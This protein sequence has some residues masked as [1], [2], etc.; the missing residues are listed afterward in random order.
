ML[1]NVKIL[2]VEDEKEIRELF[3]EALAKEGFETVLAKDG[4]EGLKKLEEHSFDLIIADI[5]MPRMDGMEMLLKARRID[6]DCFFIIVTGYAS[7]ES[8][9]Q[10]LQLGAYDYLQKPVDLREALTKFNHA[11]A[12][13]ILQKKISLIQEAS[14]RLIKV[15]D[16]EKGVK[17]TLQIILEM[18]SY[19]AATVLIHESDRSPLQFVLFHPDHQSHVQKL[20]EQSLQS[21][22]R[23]SN[24][25]VSKNNIPRIEIAEPNCTRSLSNHPLTF[26]LKIQNKTIGIVN[27]YD[28]DLDPQKKRTRDD[29]TIGM[30]QVL[31]NQFGLMVQTIQSLL[32]VQ[33]QHMQSIL[34]SMTDAV[35]MTD[36]FHRPIVLNSAAE[37]LLQGKSPGQR[38]DSN[39]ELFARLPLNLKETFLHLSQSE[40]KEF[41]QE[42]AIDSSIYQASI[43]LVKESQENILGMV[44]VFRNITHEKQIE[45]MKDDF[46]AMMTHELKTPLTNILGFASL[47]HD[48]AYG[49]IKAKQKEFIQLIESNSRHLLETINELLDL[50]KMEAGRMSYQYTTLDMKNLI[51]ES[52][53]DFLA[54]SVQKKITVEFKPSNSA[55]SVFEGDYQKIRKVLQNLLG[56]ALKFTPPEGKIK[57]ELNPL[58]ESLRVV[59]SNSGK[60]IP[61]PQLEKIFEKFY[62]IENIGQHSEGVGLG[63]AI[64]RQIISDHDG[65]IWAENNSSPVLPTEQNGGCRFIFS[66]PLHRQSK[67]VNSEE[68]VCV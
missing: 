56:N 57:I 43:S 48:P 39:L 33:Q 54:Q 40:K 28:L 37:S 21:F 27:F 24:E 26:P 4:I 30:I 18:I 65:K 3:H 64:C 5:K 29:K 10:G 31:L 44:T 12:A 7:I 41:R 2:I 17:E 9:I 1:K 42:I 11:V 6:P 45:K 25:K 49:G 62:Q 22:N 47:C 34:S 59:V 38:I 23:L 60:S 63:L 19:S 13:R 14:N 52:I 8:A 51:N 20:A 50:S 32:S 61:V 36:R 58:K 46:V 66:L 15:L 68:P 67:S 55:N 35:I 16:L 53:Q